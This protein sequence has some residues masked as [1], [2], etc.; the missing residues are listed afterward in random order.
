M[1]PKLRTRWN[2]TPRQAARLQER[3]RGRAE[4]HD[5][6]DSIRHIAGADMAFDP[7]TNL[8]FAGV[9]V[10]RFPEM[11]E[12]ER[13]MARRRLRFPYVPGLLSFREIP[14]LL[15]AFA[16]LRTEP[17][18]LLVDGHGLAHPRRF[19]IACHLGLILD[20]PAIGCAKSRLVGEHRDPAMRAGA[21]ATLYFQG[22]KVGAVLRTRTG[23]KPIYVTQG[24]RV[25]LPTALRIVR[26]CLDGFRIPKPTR[27][28]DR[29]VRELRRLYSR[30]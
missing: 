28:A 27:E 23:V 3:L 18:V 4:L 29:Y 21:T 12:V 30:P 9:I 19:G 26:K 2:L 17:D 1:R 20:K 10:Y 5:R 15:A 7:K 25:S 13:A 11:A 8:A 14:I 24:H 6:L 16:R 22:A